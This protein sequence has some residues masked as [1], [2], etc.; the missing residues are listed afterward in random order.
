MTTPRDEMNLV[1]RTAGDFAFKQIEKH[2]DFIPIAVVIGGDGEL[3]FVALGEDQVEDGGEK[4][5]VKIRN[6][7]APVQKRENTK[8]RQ[9]CRTCECAWMRPGK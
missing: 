6:S 7:F 2:A 8:S 1:C 3:H 4:D 5:L 9:L